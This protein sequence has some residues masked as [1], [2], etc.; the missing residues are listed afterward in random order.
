LGPSNGTLDELD[1]SGTLTPNHLSLIT[2]ICYGKFTMVIAADA[3]ME[4]W[5]HFDEE[6][7]MEKKCNILRAAH[8]G[9]KRGNQWERIERLSPSLV[10]ISSDPKGQHDLPDLVGSAIFLEFSNGT[11]QAAVLTYTS[12]TIKIEVS[13][14]AS[15]QRTITAF[16]D[17]PADLVFSG[18]PGPL[19]ETDWAVLLDTRL[20]T[21]A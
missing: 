14:P 8:H 9:S 5:Q 16:G 20:A 6:G 7:L 17:S 13:D 12:G 15:G 4:N 21:P 3:Q 10:V 1:R 18:Q 11:D 19:P 2:R